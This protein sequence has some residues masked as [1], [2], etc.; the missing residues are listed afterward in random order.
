MYLGTL[1]SSVFI[2]SILFILLT[3]CLFLVNYLYTL[4]NICRL[5]YVLVLIIFRLQTRLPWTDFS[6]SILWSKHIF[7]LSTVMV[8]LMFESMN[9]SYHFI[10]FF[11]IRDIK[12]YLYISTVIFPIHVSLSNFLLLEISCHDG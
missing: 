6:V 11:K 7:Q 2:Y 1:D 9:Y 8:N 3:I 4:I 12:Y 5:H 10:L